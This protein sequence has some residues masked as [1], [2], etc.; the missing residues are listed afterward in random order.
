MKLKNRFLLANSIALLYAI[1]CLY[2]AQWWINYLG[3]VL[4]NYYLALAIILFIAI[5]P[6]YLNILLLATLYVYRYHPLRIKKSDLPP[7]SLLIAAYNEEEVIRETFRGIRQ[8]DYPNQIEVVLVDDGS[9]DNTIAELEKLRLPNLKI[10]RAEHGGKANALNLGLKH[11]SHE[12]IT[13]IDADTFLYKNALTRIVSRLLSDAD[14]AAVAGH[15]LVKNERM[16][17]LSRMQSWDYMLGISA[18]KMQQGL[19]HGTLV[20]QGAFSVFK[21]K[22]LLELKG[23]RQRIGEDIVLTWALLKK[24]YRVGYEPTAFAF[25]HAP[26][27]YY[28]FFRQRQRWA[29]GMIEGFRDHINLI[30]R[31][32]QYSSFFVAIDLLFP[33]IDFFYTFVFIPGLIL[34]FFGYH[35]IVGLMTLLVLP[36]TIAIIIIMLR[37][38]MR[39]MKYAGLRMRQNPVGMVFY[40][41]FYQLIMSPICVIGYFKEIFRFKR[42]W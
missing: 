13:T 6:G 27:N 18:V 39:F 26:L 19:F 40:I 28:G 29:R 14:Y 21:K 12:I 10:I 17:R 25:T 15:V 11:C 2:L 33:F 37:S 41:L 3:R 31:G 20:A 32:Q 35:Y 34:A 23:W 7:V 1:I 5:I 8:Q 16:S 9:E 36:I 22:P 4:G 24:G 38:Q 30:W 42:K